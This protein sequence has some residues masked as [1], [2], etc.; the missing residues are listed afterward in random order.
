MLA[1][2]TALGVVAACVLLR[3]IHVAPAVE[4][5]RQQEPPALAALT[6]RPALHRAPLSAA[7]GDSLAAAAKVDFD[8][9]LGKLVDLTLRAIDALARGDTAQAKTADAEG[10]AL[11]K[12]VLEHVGDYENRA[13][14]A[15]TGTAGMADARAGTT[16]DV[17]ERLLYFGLQKLDTFARGGN[18]GALD[19]FLIALLETMVPDEQVAGVCLRLLADQPYIGAAQEDAVLRLVE[20]V[21]T[22][23]WLAEP[24]RRLLLTLWRN[25]EASGAR[26]R[27]TLATLALMLKDDSNPARR[28]AA[29]EHLL[30]SGDS[31]LI[32]FVLRDVEEQRDA[33]RAAD[34]ASAAAS[35]L[36]VDLALAAVR[37]LRVVA[38]RP[39]TAAAIELARRDGALVRATYAE[40]AQEQAA[41]ELRADLVAGLGFNPC[42]PNLALTKS[43]FDSDADVNV[44]RRALLALAANGAAAYGE[45]VV[46]AAL[47]DRELCGARGERLG[48][49]VA[50]LENMARNGE[51]EAV[52]RLG[53]RLA[54][55][56]DLAPNVR[57]ALQ[58]LLERG[59]APR[60]RK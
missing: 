38:A 31:S 44:R 53:A 27:D 7:A 36:P 15:L 34:L 56:R 24:T 14:F 48:V 51:R 9:G 41:P 5:V 19:A 49:I 50:A 40:L 60:P 16:R 13:L 26:P 52:A 17:L 28:A 12:A 58:Q 23:P 30:L 35:K 8:A 11:V 29:V 59:P 10:F 43:A 45:Q 21:P 6:D 54:Q 32:D 57:E 2:A 46:T 22:Y 37:R 4:A 42:E 55:R 1:M 3:P 47:A 18:R 20:L 39:L 25:L 33:V